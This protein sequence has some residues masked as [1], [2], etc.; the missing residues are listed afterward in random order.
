[1]QYY[2]FVHFKE[3]LTPDGEQ[4]Y[5]GLSK[6]GYN[7]ESVNEGRPVL[8]SVLGERGVRDFTIVRAKNGKF[9]ILATDLCLAYEMTRTYHES[10]CLIKRE[11]SHNLML[12]ESDDLCHFKPQREITVGHENG[13][14]CWAPDVI[15]DE[16]NDDYI[17]HWSSPRM[18]MDCKEYIDGMKMCIWYSRTKD[19][20]TFT[21][22]KILYEKEDS[23]IIDSCMIKENGRFYLFVKSEKHPCGVILLQSDKITGPFSRMNQFD[24]EMAKLAGGAGNYEA[25]CI[26]KLDKGGYVLNLDFFG[27]PGKGQGYVP[28][29]ADTMASGVFRRSDKDFSYPYGFKHGTILPISEEEYERIKTF[30]YDNE[31]YRK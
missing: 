5:F 4:V 27:L 25:P 3:K 24:E 29:V 22:A 17:L 23:G 26:Y 21:E 18:H 8:Y 9:Y 19:F 14:C 7:W 1:M 10:W 31:Q 16:E 28:F 20:K 12:W 11:G 6:D 13:G 30:D 2:L 15:Y